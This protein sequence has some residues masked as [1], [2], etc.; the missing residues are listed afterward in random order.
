MALARA[1]RAELKATFDGVLG[2]LG[3]RAVL[4]MIT[5]QILWRAASA[6]RPPSNAL[7][8][9]YWV[10]VS[11]L[12]ESAVSA[13]GNLGF[14]ACM[15]LV[16]ASPRLLNASWRVLL[17]G[18]MVAI[19]LVDLVVKLL[20][21]EA[22]IIVLVS[23]LVTPGIVTDYALHM[24]H[25]ARNAFAVAMGAATSA[26]SLLPF[27]TFPVSSVF[28]FMVVYVVMI[29]SGCAFAVALGVATRAAC[30]GDDG[31]PAGK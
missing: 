21:I 30:G 25:D 24:A 14:A 22:D 11:T 29:T 31:A 9:R 2:F 7:I 8:A 13:L 6:F 3:A 28:H 27:L 16:R 26:L 5:F 1:H 18:S 23:L 15:G 4:G 12:Q 20:A 10:E 19:L 17:G